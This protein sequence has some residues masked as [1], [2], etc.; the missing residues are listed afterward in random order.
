MKVARKSGVCEVMSGDQVIEEVE[1]MKYLGVMISSDGRME[2]E[3]EARIASATKMAGGMSERGAE[4]EGA[5]LKHKT[6]CGQC[7]DGALIVVWL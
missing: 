2:K 3:V 4:R 6:D 5:K 1:E 7:H